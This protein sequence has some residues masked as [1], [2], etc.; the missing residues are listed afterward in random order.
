MIGSSVE[1]RPITVNTQTANFIGKNRN[2][3]A[4]KQLQQ[5]SNRR[6]VCYFNEHCL[7]C[8]S[9]ITHQIYEPCKNRAKVILINLILLL[10]EKQLQMFKILFKYYVFHL[11]AHGQM[12]QPE[13]PGGNCVS[14]LCNH[15]FQCINRNCAVFYDLLCNI[16]NKFMIAY[17][18]KNKQID[19]IL[20]L[21]S[22]LY[23]WIC[24]WLLPWQC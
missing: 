11:F 1:C 14:S 23:R 2:L 16:S 22:S 19:W 6:Y 13:N 24:S 10:A 3:K 8:R 9:I 20:F 4:T 5:H 21:S 17:E 18:K 15:N 12:M 7:S